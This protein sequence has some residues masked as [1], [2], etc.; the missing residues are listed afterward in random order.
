MGQALPL[1]TPLLSGACNLDDVA[2]TTF[3]GWITPLD[4][5]VGPG[6]LTLD[7]AEFADEDDNVTMNIKNFELRDLRLTGTASC[8]IPIVG[9]IDSS[10]AVLCNIAKV[11]GQPAT[12]DVRD[13]DILDNE[14]MNKVLNFGMVQGPIMDALQNQINDAIASRVSNDDPP[15]DEEEE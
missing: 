8:D 3:L 12:V 4:V 2:V 11:Q 10:I 5:P 13:L 6:T 15:E 14:M 9:T 7:D 1:L